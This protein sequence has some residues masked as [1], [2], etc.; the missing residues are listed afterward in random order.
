MNT[1]VQAVGGSEM[2]SV[3][4]KDFFLRVIWKTKAPLV[5][6]FIEF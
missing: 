4:D 3:G 5:Y 1:R 6:N 2:N